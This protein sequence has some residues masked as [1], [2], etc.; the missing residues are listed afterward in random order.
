MNTY[1]FENIYAV[2]Q[3][4]RFATNLSNLLLISLGILL[5]MFKYRYVNFIQV[6]V[7][8]LINDFILFAKNKLY[9]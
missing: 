8:C 4:G 1:R 5:G 9:I 7:K 6:H 3:Q 2:G